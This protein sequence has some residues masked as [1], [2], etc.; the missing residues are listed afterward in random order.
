MGE[1]EGGPLAILFAA[2]HPDRARSLVLQ[3]A[4]VRERT[5]ADWP[6]GEKRRR[7][8]GPHRAI[9]E[10]GARAG[11]DLRVPSL[12][13]T[14]PARLQAWWASPAEFRDARWVGGVRSDGLRYRRSRVVPSSS[15]DADHPRAEDTCATSGMHGGW[16]STCPT[17]LRGASRRRPPALVRPRS[18]DGRDPRVLDRL[19]RGRGA[20]P[21]PRD[22]PLHRHRRLDG[23][24]D[25]TRRPPLA[26]ATGASS[27]CRTARTRAL[28]RPRGQH[29]RRRLP[30]RVRRSGTR[31]PGRRAIIEASRAWA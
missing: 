9:P 3:G 31:D 2:A 13:G 6:W 19:A 12:R 22:R 29:R 20:R 11:H 4:E 14:R 5:D 18:N 28:P 25:V 7:I 15:P 1:S 21:D 16:P 26:R 24:G 10:S 23:V 30:G 8:R 27:R 17:P